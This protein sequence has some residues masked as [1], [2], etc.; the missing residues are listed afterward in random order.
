M[1]RVLRPALLLMLILLPACSDSVTGPGTDIA[2]QVIGVGYYSLYKAQGA[3]VVRDA[4]T[5]A[6]VLPNLDLRTGP[7]GAPGPAPT[8]DFSKEMALIVCLGGRS[9]GGYDV[10]VDQVLDGGSEIVAKAAEEAP[11]PNCAVTLAF[12]APL[13]VVVIPQDARP[14]RLEWSK[15][16]RAC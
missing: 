10:R 13:V 6:Q 11:G 8:I 9:S 1:P 7:G 3:L 14:V 15:T 4:A 5:W 12:T 16:V 2:F